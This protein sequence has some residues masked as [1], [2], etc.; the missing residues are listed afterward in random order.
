MIRKTILRIVAGFLIGAGAGLALFFA[1]NPDRNPLVGQESEGSNGTPKRGSPAPV[2][3]LNNLKGE[4]VDLNDFRGS[5]VLLNFW[6][7]WCA[8]CR[9]EMPEFQARYEEFAPNLEIVAVDFAEP[10]DLV[11]E[12]V[13]E[14]GLTFQVLL[15]PDAQVQD[16]YRIR[17]YPSSLF[18]DRDGIVQIVHIGIMHEDQLDR[19][20]IDMGVSE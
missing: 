20:L 1:L 14:F 4:K 3:T 19:Y 15:D 8:P 13:D 9:L 11:Q 17:G 7:T 2:F 6:A 12:F 5:V 18:I 16:L 10:S